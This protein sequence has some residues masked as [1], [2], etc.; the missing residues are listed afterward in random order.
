MLIGLVD[1]FAAPLRPPLQEGGDVLQ[2]ISCY[3]KA[4]AL[5]PDFPDAFANLVHSL[6]FVCDWSNRD[7]DFAALKKMLATQVCVCV[8]VCVEAGKLESG[9]ERRR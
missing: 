8:C 5:R 9:R 1:A 6:V 2:A 4:L 7:Q 3:R